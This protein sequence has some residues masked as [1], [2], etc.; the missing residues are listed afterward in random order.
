MDYDPRNQNTARKVSRQ[1]RIKQ[2]TPAFLAGREFVGVHGC[3]DATYCSGQGRLL[4]SALVLKHINRLRP[5]V[6]GQFSLSNRESD[7]SANNS[8]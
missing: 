5:V 2:W 1:K 6:F 8:G 7:R 4:R 3:E